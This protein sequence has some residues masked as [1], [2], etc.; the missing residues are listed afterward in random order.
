MSYQP[1]LFI[2]KL[3]SVS[4][5]YD[6]VVAITG[7]T[8]SG[9][10]TI[11]NV[12]AFD[13]TQDVNLLRIGQTLN[14]ITG[15]GFSSDVTITDI[16]GTTLTV[17]TTA[18]ASQTGGI[19][20]ADMAAGTYFINSAS[21]N[22]PQNNLN[23]NDITGSVDADYDGSTPIYAIVGQASPTLGGSAISGKF[24]LYKITEV[25]YRDIGSSEFS[26]FIEWGEPGQESDSNEV[27][28]TG[29]TQ[30]LAI[31][32]MSTTSSQVTI[33][34]DDI[35]LGTPAGSDIAP[36]QI[37]LPEIIDQALTSSNAF[38][39]T[40][41]AQITGSLSI[42]GSSTFALNPNQTGDFFLIKSSSFNPLKVNSDGVAIF[43]KFLNTLP[44][45]TEGGIAYS[46]SNLYVGLE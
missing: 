44:T 8:V 43:G 21:F 20:T 32:A 4:P 1:Q 6:N 30:T 36:Y 13:S 24:H 12:A 10:N 15:G 3:P 2:G 33:Y 18:A 28:F 19:F 37:T 25:T 26:A 42:T 39:F 31:G 27:L 35:I 38:P 9:E 11:T 5:L 45:A 29:A 41:S 23:V 40:G 16:S 34:G 22:D 14:T 17:N 46:G 7:T